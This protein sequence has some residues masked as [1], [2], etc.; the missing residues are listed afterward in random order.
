VLPVT[1]VIPLVWEAT[2]RPNEEVKEFLNSAFINEFTSRRRIITVQTQA[3]TVK[4]CVRAV[5]AWHEYLKR[6][7]SDLYTAAQSMEQDA[8]AERSM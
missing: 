3:L 7:T 2:G 4:Y 5:I 6:S 1:D 8:T